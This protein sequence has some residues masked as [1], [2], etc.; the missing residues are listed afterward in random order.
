MRKKPH[1]RILRRKP[2][3]QYLS[4]VLKSYLKSYNLQNIVKTITRH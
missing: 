3:E 1:D 4:T 2:K